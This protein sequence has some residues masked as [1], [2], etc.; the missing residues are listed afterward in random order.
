MV[1]NMKGA[2]IGLNN[3]ALGRWSYV[4]NAWQIIK[5]L[6]INMLK[7]LGG[8]EGN[9]LH[10][11]MTRNPDEW[12]Q[13]LYNLLNL[14]GSNGCKAYF[15]CI[16]SSWANLLGI[17][18]PPQGTGPYPPVSLD[19]AKAMIDQLAGD[20]LLEY[21]FINDPRLIGWVPMNEADITDPMVLDWGLQ[22]CDYIKSKGGRAWL[23]SP[24]GIGGWYYG[25][26]FHVTE[27]IL[28][29]H[30]D[31]LDRHL[32]EVW[33]FA[34]PCERDYQKFYDYYRSVLQN[35]VLDGRG[36]FPIDSLIV[37]EFGIWRGYG[38]DLGYSGS[39]TDQERETY[40]NAVYN[41]LEDAGIKNVFFHYLFAQQHEGIYEDN[42][43]DIVDTDSIY[44]LPTGI[45]KSNYT[46]PI[47]PLRVLLKLSPF[48]AGGFL[49][50]RGRG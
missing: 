38:S 24:R 2:A 8:I 19:E 13:N 35:H 26:D 3:L 33:N 29:G 14:I 16:G 32:Y 34:N 5:D 12:A 44:Y 11:H 45:V 30:V 7:L 25:E 6:R 18:P 47:S 39:F 28:Y 22:M 50:S 37:G 17:V 41:A 9:V 31:Y 1:F 42:R 4:P 40:Y 10:I 43:F 49:I 21:D 48:L 36:R 27:P 23:A 46:T 15:H 20:N